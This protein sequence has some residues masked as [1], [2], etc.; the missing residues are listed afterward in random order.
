MSYIDTIMMFLQP[1]PLP[2][3]YPEDDH[4]A[5]PRWWIRTGIHAVEELY[6]A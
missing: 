4:F 1:C 6:E 5:Y 2:S 3:L